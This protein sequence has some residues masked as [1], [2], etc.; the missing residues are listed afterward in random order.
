MKRSRTTALLLMSTAPLLFTACQK[1]QAVQVQE[2]LYTSV[3]ACSEATGDP[4]SCRQAFAT[5]QQQSADVAPQYASREACAAEYP[6]DQC[7]Q[8]RTSTGHSFV[9]PMMMG[10]FMSQML[11]NGRAAATPAAQPAFR[12]K[13]NGWAKPA[14]APGGSGG[15]NTGSRIGAGKA[16]LAPVAAEPNRAVTASR[17]GFG[18]RSGGRSSSGG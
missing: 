18:A 15:L 5:A 13:A 3:E 14:A 1:E 12:D 17:G 11:N 4:S 10:F 2:G 7:V 8:Q 9:G 16:G 6:A